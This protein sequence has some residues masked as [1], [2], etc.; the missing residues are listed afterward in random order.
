MALVTI[1]GNAWDGDRAPIPAVQQ[2]RLWAVPDRSFT[3]GNGMFTQNEVLADL[4]I[5]TG[6]FTARI[7]SLPGVRWRFR[8][9]W[10]I[11][12]QEDEEPGNRA[13]GY[14]EWDWFHPAAGGDIG[15]LGPALTVGVMWIGPTEPPS[16][17]PGTRW[18]VTDPA[19]SNYGLILKWS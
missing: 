9:D 1:T 14:E 6:Q 15:D 5:D 4:D 7:E 12:G 8:L 18:L 16:K 13:R 17:L 19:S 11:P 3:S 10:L 2:P